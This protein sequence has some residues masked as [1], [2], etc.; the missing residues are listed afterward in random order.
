MPER[1][2]KI[3]R[4]W[5]GFALFIVVML[6]FRSAIADW[7]QVPSG[8]MLPTIL[9]GD[10]IIVD[11]LAYDLRVPFT[12]KRLLRWHEPARG[13]VVTFPSPEDE[14]LL[15][16]RIVGIPGDVVE[17]KNNVLIINGE[18]ASYTPIEQSEL[19]D[20]PIDEAFRYRF[21]KESVLGNE[22]MIMLH[23]SR[24]TSSASSYG[25]VTVPQGHYLM[26][27]DNRDN[28]RDS[29]VIGFV[30]RD[31]ILGRA[32]SIAF[33]LDYDHYY[34]PR[35]ERFFTPLPLEPAAG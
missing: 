31:R 8:S 10:R 16:K 22:R 14:R 19:V 30:S 17:L 35:T 12:L 28:S 25:P 27:G 11:K 13:D 26:L 1:L 2:T 32:E 23:E 7:N 15:V 20:A 24:Y 33:S 5:R 18:R 34:Q 3:W 9:V 29:R 21:Y 6:V 4:D